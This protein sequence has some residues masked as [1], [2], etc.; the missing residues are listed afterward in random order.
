MKFEPID[1]EMIIALNIKRLFV[2]IEDT[3]EG[4]AFD[5]LKKSGRKDVK[6]YLHWDSITEE[7]SDVGYDIEPDKQYYILTKD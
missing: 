3:E 1:Y 4:I 2:I 5:Q 7:W 6:D